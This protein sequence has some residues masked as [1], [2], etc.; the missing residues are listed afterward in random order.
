MGL[1]LSLHPSFVASAESVAVCDR[2]ALAASQ[3][4]GVPLNVLLSVTRIETGRN[5]P[6]GLTPWP[7][8]LNIAGRGY[9]L[10]EKRSAEGLAARTVESGVTSFD[11]GCFQ[12]NYRWHGQHFK[13]LD[14]MLDPWPNALYAAR[15]LRRLHDEFG[16]WSGAV[17]A[18]HSR[19]P[20]HSERYLRK[21]NRVLATLDV[22][23]ISEQAGSHTIV[24][25]GNSA[26]LVPVFGETGETRLS[27]LWRQN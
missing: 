18:Y 16:S 19:N 4:T 13:S 8:T 17:A 11:V 24:V 7:W 25:S 5:G 21:F 27:S 20:V 10:E 9:W 12:I 2:A 23:T 15:F 1:L 6:E 14:H 3:S 22:G 26:S